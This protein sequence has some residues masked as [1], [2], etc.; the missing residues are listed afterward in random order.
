[1]GRFSIGPNEGLRRGEQGIGDGLSVTA[2][3]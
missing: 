1:M 3:R 2:C